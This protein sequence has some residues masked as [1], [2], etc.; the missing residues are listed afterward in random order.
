MRLTSRSRRRLAVFLTSLVASTVAA[1]AAVPADAPGG[2]SWDGVPE[3]LREARRHILDSNINTLTF[4]SMDS[5][6]ETREVARSGPVWR[7]PRQDRALDFSYS[8][9]GETHRAAEFAERNRTNAML[10]LKRGRIV[11]ESYYNLTDERTHFISF[12]MAKSITSTLIGLALADH[13]IRSLDDLVGT[14][15]P[16]LSN[17]DYGKV[18]IRQV[19]RMRSGIAFDERYDFGVHSQAQEVFENAIVRNEERFAYLAPHLKRRDK[20]PGYFNYST[21]DTA[22]L[23]L[24]LEGAVG[25]PLSTYMTAKLWEPLGAEASGFWLADGPP[26]VGRALSGM[27]YNAVLRD[28]A[29]VGE[30]MLR[31]GRAGARQIVSSDWINLVTSSTAIEN[32]QGLVPSEFGYGYQWWTLHGKGSYFALG[33]QGQFIFV[34]P[35]S[36]TVIVKLSYWPPGDDSAFMD[37]AIS[38]FESATAWKG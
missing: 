7:L 34:D 11:H 24:V 8:V 36:E 16:E 12:S 38:F 13:K 27:G 20:N 15:V 18:S 35:A 2:S 9:R 33:L 21:M 23:G 25:E 6:F 17:S 32:S 29:R 1:S 5:L 4:R 26:G 14:Y 19:M 10:I 28:Y 37:E 31:Q 30:M 22:V 3:A